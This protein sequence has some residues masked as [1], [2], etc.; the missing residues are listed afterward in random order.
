MIYSIMIVVLETVQPIMT[1]YC[2]NC[3]Y[4]NNA[5]IIL[6][7]IIIT[8]MLIIYDNMMMITNKNTGERQSWDNLWI[9]CSYA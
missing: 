9:F 2:T 8:N 5:Y 6:I 4:R 7:L 3:F 1:Y